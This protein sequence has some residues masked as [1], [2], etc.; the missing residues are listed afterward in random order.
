MRS[1]IRLNKSG[2]K[3]ASCSHRARDLAK[4]VNIFPSS[5]NIQVQ[6]RTDSPGTKSS[7]NSIG[8]YVV[9]TTAMSERHYF[10]V[11]L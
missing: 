2:R 9:T 5:E 8:M 6:K 3:P 4:F 7:A 10:G 11:R 1:I